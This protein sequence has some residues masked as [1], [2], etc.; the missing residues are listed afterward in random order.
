MSEG[1]AETSAPIEAPPIPSPEEPK[2]ETGAAETSAPIE[3]PPI[4]T[5]EEPKVDTGAA[6]TSAPI[7]A[8]PFPIPEEPKVDTDEDEDEYDYTKNPFKYMDTDI[9]VFRSK[10]IKASKEERHR[11]QK[12]KIAEKT[13]FSSRAKT[14]AYSNRS[15]VLEEGAKEEDVKKKESE[16]LTCD[17]T[18]ALCNIHRCPGDKDSLKDYIAKKRD[19]FLAQ[20]SVAVKQEAMRTMEAILQI[21]EKKILDS[22]NKLEED[23]IA[24]EEFLNTNDRKS[25]DALRMADLETKLKFEKNIEIKK[26]SGVMMA[27]KSDISKKEEILKEFLMYRDFLKNLSPVEWQEQ[28][29]K[30]K[31]LALKAKQREK[32]KKQHRDSHLLAFPPIGQGADGRVPRTASKIDSKE[33]R[34]QSRY[35]TS[36]SENRRSSARSPSVSHE[37]KEKESQKEVLIDESDLDEDPEIYFTD[38]EQLLEVFLDLEEQNLTLIQNCQETDETL[39]EIRDRGFKIQQKLS[40]KT[41]T[42]Q[43]HL[44]NLGVACNREEEKVEDL[45]LKAKMFSY[46]EFKSEQD[47]TLTMLHKKVAE[48]YQSAIGEI[49]AAFSTLQMLAVIENRLEQLHESLESVPKHKLEAAEKAKQKERRMR[50][51]AEKLKQQMIHQEERLKRAFER[52]TADPKIMLGRKLM[53]RSEPPRSKLKKSDSDMAS[54]IQEDHL[55]FFT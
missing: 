26:A 19:M 22:E 10:A 13:T 3:A 9:F 49:Q 46:G 37:E 14:H 47:I 24:F 6:E 29:A 34:S 41:E 45:Q 2:V 42:L 51:R 17:A 32:Q 15:Y 55:Y 31:L 33:G 11:Q 23:T 25:A 38:P 50:I 27:I 5:P 35:R 30:K 20:Y 28:Q 48:V 1:A 12:L 44:E 39:E 16:G 43:G 8:P 36:F 7:E 18:F 52:A 40:Q 4:P 54:K 21:E 53:F